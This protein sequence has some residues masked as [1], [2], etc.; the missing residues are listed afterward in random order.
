MYPIGDHRIFKIE[1]FIE[2]YITRF[3][4]QLSEYPQ[5]RQF[6]KKRRDVEDCVGGDDVCHRESVSDKDLKRVAVETKILA[7]I[8]SLGN[9]Y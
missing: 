1:D 3:F 6:C 9:N 4:P 5:P 2:D 8:C 7:L